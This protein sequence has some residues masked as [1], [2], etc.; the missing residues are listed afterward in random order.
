MG[1]E[2]E[3]P[4]FINNKNLHIAIKYENAFVLPLAYMEYCGIK[5]DKEK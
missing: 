4:C 3:I 2:I 1:Q 5:L